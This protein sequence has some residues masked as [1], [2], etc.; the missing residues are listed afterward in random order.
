M[1][2]ISFET[3]MTMPDILASL[4]PAPQ[5]LKAL[6][7]IRMLL[8]LAASPKRTLILVLFIYPKLTLTPLRH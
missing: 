7:I 6:E 3:L 8:L 5:A 2:E 1:I 4:M